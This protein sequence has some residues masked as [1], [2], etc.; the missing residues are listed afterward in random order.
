MSAQQVILIVGVVALVAAVA[1]AALAAWTYRALDIRGVRADL[2]GRARAR[3]VAG[4]S[5]SGVS[6]RSAVRAFSDATWGGSVRERSDERGAPDRE[7]RTRRVPRPAASPPPAPPSRRDEA[8]PRGTGDE[9]TSLMGPASG[10]DDPTTVAAPGADDPTTVADA[11][12]EFHV[13]RRESGTG[14]SQRIEG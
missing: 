8:G 1:L 4:Q 11:S 7:D 10:S 14:S 5:S 12:F 3:E 13:V 2:S 6:R 9:P